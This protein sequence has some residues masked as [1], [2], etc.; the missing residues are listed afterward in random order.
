[1]ANHH[2]ITFYSIEQIENNKKLGRVIERFCIKNKIVGTFFSTPQGV[3]TTLS[4]TKNSLEELIKLLEKKFKLTLKDQT[5]SI[6]ASVP[7]KRLKIKCREN[8][9]PLDGDFD[10]VE[11]RGRHLNATEWNDLVLDPDTLVIDVRNDYETKIGTF[12]EST[13]PNMKNF[14]EFP[15]FV[16]N[17][18]SDKKDKKIAMFC[19]GGIR[20]EIA[21]SFMIN[22]GFDEV[23]Q[24]DGGVLKYLKEVEEDK[25]L[26]EGECFVF[27]E[28]VT[29]NK[30]LERGDYYQCFGCRRPLSKIDLQSDH[31]VKGV[32]CHMCYQSSSEEDKSRFAQRQKQIDLAEQRGHQHMG[33]KEKQTR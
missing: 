27:D 33:M 16:K 19:T 6:S 28:R 3:N 26:W 2:V 20:C 13:I 25:N 11:S 4:G 5:W 7:F 18:L 30:N 29:V 32:S 8:L 9:L 12:Q 21:S 15:S 10:P 17:K 14:T 23:Y 24:L 1:M 31:Y 22:E